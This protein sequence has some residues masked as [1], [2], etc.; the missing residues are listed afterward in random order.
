MSA[1]TALPCAAAVRRSGTVGRVA[2]L[3]LKLVQFTVPAG[4]PVDVPVVLVRWFHD[5]PPVRIEPPP[6]AAAVAAAFGGGLRR[7][8]DAWARLSLT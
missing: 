3:R 2:G 8:C 7:R 4:A 5:A 1:T 6:P